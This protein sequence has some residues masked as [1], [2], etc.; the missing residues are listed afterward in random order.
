MD[1]Q[2]IF[3]WEK[4]WNEKVNIPIEIQRGSFKIEENINLAFNKR[5]SVIIIKAVVDI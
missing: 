2:I 1:K 4:C 3:A 5:E